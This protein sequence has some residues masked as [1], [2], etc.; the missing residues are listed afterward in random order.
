[1]HLIASLLILIIESCITSN[2]V[3]LLIN[4][5]RIAVIYLK[6]MYEV[7]S[8]EYLNFNDKINT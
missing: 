8:P 6:R 7:S 4:F 1:M 2:E 3:L 5:R